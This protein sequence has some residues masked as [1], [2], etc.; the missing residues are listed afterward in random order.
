[1]A[2]DL[3]SKEEQNKF[4]QENLSSLLESINDTFGP[5]LVDELMSRLR[6]TINE[7]NIEITSA[8]DDLKT[9]ENNRQK[10]YEMIREGNIPIDKN[11]QDEK[12]LSEWEQKIEEIESQK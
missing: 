4:I 6:F 11:S 5:I 7:F 10:M 8:F 3:K 9:K 1:M 12:E 2:I